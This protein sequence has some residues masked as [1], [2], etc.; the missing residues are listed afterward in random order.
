MYIINRIVKKIYR[1]IYMGIYFL[2]VMKINDI[3]FF[4][5]VKCL[6]EVKKKF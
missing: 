5:Y 4:F 6:I 3:N 2:C 1:K